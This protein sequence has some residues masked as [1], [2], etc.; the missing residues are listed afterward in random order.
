MIEAGDYRMIKESI[1]AMLN[2]QVNAEYYSAYLYL[3]MA[4]CADRAGYKGIA[5][6]LYVQ[7]KEEMA[8]GTHI[9]E[10]ILERGAAPCL[11]EI[12]APPASYNG[13]TE[14]F[15]KVLA[16]EQMVTERI[17]RIATLA[18]QEK[19]HATYQFISWYVS[20]QVEEEASADELLTR[21]KL[22]DGHPGPLYNLDA[23]LAGRVF[24][25]PFA[26]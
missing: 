6:W 14:I 26:D 4:A 8:H 19:D 22:I 25:D 21:V 16:H 12:K 5:H 15:E 23:A 7:A 2:D 10:Y 13:I 11:G 3:S 9:F 24:T 17:N 1:S 18:E 20:E